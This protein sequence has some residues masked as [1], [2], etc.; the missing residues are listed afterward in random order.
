MQRYRKFIMSIKLNAKSTPSQTIMVWDLLVRIFHW[1]LVLSFFTAY[2]TEDDFQALHVWAGYT[3]ISL[4]FTRILWGF[5]GTTHAKF[6]DFYY[7]KHQII[8]FIKETLQYKAKRFIGHNPAGGAMIFL[9]LISLVITTITGLFLYGL[10]EGQGPL[11]SLPYQNWLSVK[12][13]INELHDFFAN[14]TLFLILIHII[15]VLIESIIHKENLIHSMISGKK[16]EN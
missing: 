14:F 8:V 15:G 9:L 4:L 5:I 7:S 10:E 1:T 6:S 11:A 3:I 2:F 16:H 12:K 13:Y